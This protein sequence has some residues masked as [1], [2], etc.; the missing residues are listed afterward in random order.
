[1]KLNSLI[2][3][4]LLLVATSCAYDEFEYLD[5]GELSTKGLHIIGAVEDFDSKVVG[6]R[7]GEG[8]IADSYISE[9]T[10][11]VFDKNNN[12]VQGYS[13]R[14][15]KSTDSEGNPTEVEFDDA[16]KCPSA[17]NI[18]KANPTFLIST[19]EGIFA[20]LDGDDP[21]MIF[22]DFDDA[23]LDQ[24][25]IYIVANAWHQIESKL[26]EIKT[27]NDL[28]ALTLDIDATLAM[29][30]DGEG[31][32]RGFPM[33]GTTQGDATFN[34]KKDGTNEN[35]VA[36]IP[37]KK[38]YSKVCFSMQVNANQVVSG[39]IPKFQIEKAEVF[40]VPTKARLGRDLD[41]SGKPVYGTGSTDDYITEIAGGTVSDSNIGDYYQFIGNGV[42][43]FVINNFSRSTIY[44]TS[45]LQ[46][47]DE[48]LIEFAFYMP[49]HKVTPNPVTYPEN[50]PDEL[51]QYYKPK[52][53]GV[54]RND[55]GTQSAA[56]IATFVRIHG[57]YTDHNG[58]IKTVRYDI[59]LGQ[60]N[61]SDFTI[62]RNQQ[63]NN[64]LVI[65]GL[66]NYHDAYTDKD[67]NISIDHRVDV[68]D[69][70]F[71]L[72][73]E[74]TA[75]LDAHFEVRPLDI[76]LSPGSKITITIPEEYQSWI[77]MESDAKAQEAIGDKAKANL[78]V[79]NSTKRRGVRRYFTTDLVSELNSTNGGELTI[80]HSNSEDTKNK[81]EIH[82][83]W[84]YIDENVNVYDKLLD[85]GVINVKDSPTDGSY[86]VGDEYYRVGK[87]KFQYTDKDGNQSVTPVTI[88]FQQWNLWRV[89]SS[90]RQR[91]YDIEHE[92]EYL[93]NYAS[94][95][96]YGETQNG[97]AW[98]LDGI[99][100]S[101]K[102]IAYWK[103]NTSDSW[104]AWIIDYFFNTSGTANN[105]FANSGVA[106]LYDFYLT[107][108]A[109]PVTKLDAGAIESDYKRDYQGLAFNKEIAATLLKNH[110]SDPK[111]KIN[112]VILTED[113]VSAFAYCYNKNKR[114]TD[115]DVC[116]LNGG[117]VDT[118]NLKWH[119]PS[120]DEIE[121]IALGAYDEFDKV[122]QNQR[123]WS[124]QPAFD[125][126]SL[127]LGARRYL[128]ALYVDL[129]VDLSGEYYNDD[130]DRARATSVYATGSD[131]YTTIK[132]GLPN[133]KKSGHLEVVAY[134]GGPKDGTAETT[135]TIT[136]IDY[137]ADIFKTEYA[138][139]LKR[140]TSCRIRAV[141]RSG[142]K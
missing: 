8:E 80:S 32:Y 62:K 34:L 72:S 117:T 45:A 67:D 109:F 12:I 21:T 105:V 134:K 23:N 16:D 15:V 121:D 20:N 87:V 128:I 3:T 57:T 123:Y 93:N 131:T 70:G 51:K 64:K 9:M 101:N 31:K 73:M 89:W 126:N 38:L 92:E 141:Y 127:H 48:Y 52:C 136:P 138:G 82:R 110:S 69:K 26:G 4:L 103:E 115:G 132:S 25:K 119:L 7:A 94:D 99:Q 44:H 106:P 17:I 102:V 40:N 30:K 55:D 90:D 1:M 140:N 85:E 49:E 137:T 104:L 97:M 53:V 35:S 86:S 83:V 41:E 11:F 54:V 74:R 122:F 10:M 19:E 91:Y 142:T 43:P 75:I 5:R 60:D 76:E 68:D 13:D 36:N 133:D 96:Q 78:Y 46:P 59:Y 14:T 130:L 47:T 88:N 95:Q 56:K 50:M 114:N 124:C 81:T 129:L 29:P 6:T 24:C 63:L 139:N 71:N 125:Y 100:L 2:L 112:D 84:F 77:A 113:P 79:D 18:R 42:E 33:M 135:L 108:D 22:Y 98:G 39:Q 118:S 120:I 66:T 28:K 58:Q 61:H 116:V 27:L 37:L 107:R 65:Q 111:A